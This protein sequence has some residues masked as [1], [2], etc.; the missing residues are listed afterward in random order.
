[1][2]K[3]LL[4]AGIAMM[5]IAISSCDEDT[6]TLGDSLTSNVDKFLSVTQT[7]RVETQSIMTDSVLAQSLYRYLGKIKDPETGSFITCDYMTQFNILEGESSAIFPSQDMIAKDGNG[8]PMADS[9]VIRIMINS[10]QG[11]S[12]TAMK[13]KVCELNRPVPNSAKYYTDFD[14]EEEG[15]LRTTNAINISKTYSVSDLTQ[16][17]S[18]RNVLRGSSYYQYITIPLSAA[19]TDKD[20]NTYAG[21]DSSTKA[22]TGFGTYLLRMYYDHPEYFKN[23]NTFA[24]KVCPGFY[25]KSVDGQG[26]MIEIANTQILVYYHYTSS[27]A[28]VNSSRAFMSTQEVLQTTHITNDKAGIKT[29]EKIDTCTFLKTPSGIFTEVSLPIDSIKWLK[30]KDANGAELASHESDTIMSAKITFQ[31]MKSHSDL[32]NSL[33]EEPSNLLMIPRDRLYSFFENNLTPDNITS[34]LATY[35]STQKTYTFN[36]LTNLINSIYND[37]KPEI[38]NADGSINLTK[39]EVYKAA[40]PNWNKVVLVPVSL[41]TTTSSGYSTVTAISNSL[42]I[43]SVRLVGG[44]NNKHTPIT[45]T[46]MYNKNE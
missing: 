45:I 20:G 30:Q 39:V 15:Y 36:T 1:M 42:N 18:M 33:L 7:Y 12:L 16:S 43:S 46:I 21:Y 41:T 29:L 34:Y 2:I 32:S 19:Y 4:L 11:D 37:M 31:Q 25:F 14:P 40:H 13:M 17:D 28:T 35:N 26:N 10:F 27:G 23:S 22:G 24:R 5:T 6:M 9:C 38:T 8:K 3:K 44:K